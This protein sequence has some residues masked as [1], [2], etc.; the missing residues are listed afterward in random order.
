MAEALSPLTSLISKK[1]RKML[2]DYREMR[3]VLGDGDAADNTA[4]LILEDLS[5]RKAKGQ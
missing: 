3:A 2:D 4:R 5:A 1:R